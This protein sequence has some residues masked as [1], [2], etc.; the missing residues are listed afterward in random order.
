MDEQEDLCLHIHPSQLI[1]CMKLKG[2]KG[3]HWF[4]ARWNDDGSWPVEE[5]ERRPGPSR[6]GGKS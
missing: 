4:A 5:P 3:A 6:R 1:N 2:H